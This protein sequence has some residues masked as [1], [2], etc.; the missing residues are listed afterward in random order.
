MLTNKAMT[1]YQRDRK[2]IIGTLSLALRGKYISMGPH[3]DC[4][5]YS[6]L[7]CNGSQNESGIHTMAI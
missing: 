5:G 6:R 3:G 2:L 7:K 1:Q 4:S